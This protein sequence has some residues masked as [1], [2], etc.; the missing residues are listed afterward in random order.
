MTPEVSFDGSIQASFP[1]E[2]TLTCD[3]DLRRFPFDEQVCTFRLGSLSYP[4]DMVRLGPGAVNGVEVFRAAKSGGGYVG[5][6]SAID[7]ESPFY[8]NAEF[9][10]ERIRTTVRHTARGGEVEFAELEFEMRL[11]RQALSYLISLFLPSLCW[12]ADWPLCGGGMK[13]GPWL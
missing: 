1:L 10:L 2:Q 9:I 3:M 8:H 5:N 11:Q 6:H 13:K 12:L 4:A 7:L